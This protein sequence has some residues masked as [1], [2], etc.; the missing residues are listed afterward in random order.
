M[1]WAEIRPMTAADIN[2]ANG[3]GLAQGFRDRRRFYDFV[4]RVPTAQPL[5]GVAD[6]H[7]IATGLATVNGP[8]G[9]IGGIVVAEAYR[10][11]GLGRA[12]TDEL[13]GR[14]RA[15]GC[16]TLS[17]ESTEIGRPLYER[18]G[19]RVETHYRQVQ[20][21]R[22]ESA[23]EL[24]AGARV[25]KLEPADLPAVIELDRRATAEDRSAALAVMAQAGGWVLERDAAVAGFLLPAERAYGAIVAPRLEDGLFLLDLHR[26]VV[27]PGGHVRAGVPDEHEAG[28][29]ELLARGW[30]ETWRAPRMLLGPSIPWRP[31][32]IWGQINSAMG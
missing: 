24:P 31:D 11:R 20:A 19:F 18:L 5:V 21:D 23:P 9:W 12:V 22:I 17:L 27:P 1:Q 25:R 26:S 13:I 29:Q 14:L 3:L 32:W 4:L 7:V 28:W 2:A 30:R 10:R 16:E 15:A 8:V 6:G